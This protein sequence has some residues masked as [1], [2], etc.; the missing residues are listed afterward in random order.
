[1]CWRELRVAHS[2]NARSLSATWTFP[3]PFVD[4]PVV[5]SPTLPTSSGKY[6]SGLALASLGHPFT[7]AG[8]TTSSAT[9]YVWENSSPFT[10]GQWIDLMV[11]AIGRWK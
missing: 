9:I 10:S 1:M 6:S 11:F 5:P 8:A 4:A 3:Q 2:G 7:A